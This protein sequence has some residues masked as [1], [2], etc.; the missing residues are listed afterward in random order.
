MGRVVLG[1]MNF[2]ARVP[3]REALSIVARAVERG[4]VWL[5]T[6]DSYGNGESEKIV[7]QARKGH[8]ASLRIA[9][10]VGL[11]AIDRKPEGLSPASIARA[12]DESRKH[13]GVDTIDLYY[14]HAPDPHTPL[15]SSIEAFASLVERGAIAAWGVSNFA[16]WQLV[17]IDTLCVA[18]G[19]PKPVASQVL[20]NL[21]IRQ[22][23]LEYLPC[24]AARS[25]SMPIET[26]VYNALAGGLLARLPAPGDAPPKGS[27]FDRLAFYRSRYWS[28]PMIQAAHAYA[29]IARE[30][31]LDPPTLAHRFVASRAGVDAVL[32]GPT[33]T[34][35]LDAAID[36]CATTLD[37]STMKRLDA[38]AVALAGT[39]ARYAR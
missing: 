13:L 35:Q 16:A 32:V 7:G 22:I 6:A 17:E 29:T 31:G 14:A 11:R 30:I 10:K 15:E 19:W 28:P 5:D 38:L 12:C 25:S 26:V 4:V 8:G 21:L 33:S 27:R 9:S 2:G 24:V 34:A 37:D 1:A 23:E 20:Y 36:A 18:R 3:A 39:D